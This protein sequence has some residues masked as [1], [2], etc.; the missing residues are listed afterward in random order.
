MVAADERDGNTARADLLQLGDG[1]KMFAGDHAAILEPEIEQIAREQEVIAWLRDF[2]QKR[3]ERLADG[4][5]N[6]AEV[7]VCDDDHAWSV[8]GS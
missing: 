4:G 6:L 3:V 7:R 5:R 8:C 2:L 1:G